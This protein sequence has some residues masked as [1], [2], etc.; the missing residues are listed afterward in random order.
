M[1]E[2][3]TGAPEKDLEP[4]PECGN[5]YV[6][7][8]VMLTCGGTLSRGQI[9]EQNRDDDGNPVGRANENTILDSL[10]YLVDF[11]YGEV[12]ELASN[13]I[14]E[15]INACVTQKELG[16]IFDCIVYFKRDRNTMTLT[17]QNFVKSRGKA[18]NQRSTKGRQLCCKWKD[19][20]T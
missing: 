1:T 4:T 20:S 6:N 12:T 3:T 19:G 13:N 2:G 8:Y 11:E 10:N 7:K 18:K 15:S 17:N 14:S 16:S 9:I 5:K